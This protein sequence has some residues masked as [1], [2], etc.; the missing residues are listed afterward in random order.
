VDSSFAI[1]KIPALR[2]LPGGRERVKGLVLLA[3]D[4]LPKAPEQQPQLA[5][6]ADVAA[7]LAQL[8]SKTRD[9][10]GDAAATG[11]SHFGYKAGHDVECSRLF[12]DLQCVESCPV[13]T[14]EQ[15]IETAVL[16][17]QVLGCWQQ[18]QGTKSNHQSAIEC[19]ESALA[20]AVTLP[21]SEASVRFRY[22]LFSVEA[23]KEIGGGKERAIANL[24]R[25]LELAPE[26]SDLY[27][28]CAEELQRLKKKSWGLF[29]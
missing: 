23:P 12:R 26:Q 18:A 27:R 24:E 10:F 7:Y 20:L 25:A 19:Y 28:K 4:R 5:S 9:L 1:G 2:L 15:R 3:I 11:R 22:A 17:A 14:L 29:G 8:G 16:K 13:A 21:E 6:V